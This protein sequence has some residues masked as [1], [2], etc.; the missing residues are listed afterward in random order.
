MK[1]ELFLCHLA[2]VLIAAL[3]L[4]SMRYE[5]TEK[6]ATRLEWALPPVLAVVVAAVLLIVSP[7]KRT[8]LWTVAIYA[9]FAIG[10]GVGL[11]LKVDQDFARKLV[12]VHRTWDGVIAAALLLLAALARF[13]SSDLMGRQS[14][15]YG[16]LGGAAGFLAAYLCGRVITLRY[17]KA[18]QARHLDMIRGEK[19]KTE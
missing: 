3:A 14:A 5:F 4:R 1:V 2:A 19:P 8:E 7:G 6:A 9:G 13:V 10:L 17:Y 12:R 15:K 18:R 16:V 11:M